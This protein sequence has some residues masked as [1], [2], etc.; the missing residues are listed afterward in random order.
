MFLLLSFIG[1]IGVELQA[2]SK[3]DIP[4]KDDTKKEGSR[5]RLPVKQSIECYY[6]D[7][8]IY[9]EFAIPEGN[10][11]IIVTDLSTM[12]DV[13]SVYSTIMPCTVYIGEINNSQAIE[14]RTEKGNTYIG[15]LYF[16]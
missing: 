9:V 5:K 1:I 11:E 13:S 14:I 2:N 3:I 10:A 6:L 15:Q 8:V 4:I 12:S 16:Y 7:G